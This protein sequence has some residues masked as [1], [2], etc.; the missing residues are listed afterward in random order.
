MIDSK[1]LENKKYNLG[2]KANSLIILTQHKIPVPSFVVIAKED[3][4]MFLKENKLFL[5]LKKWFENEQYDLIKQ[6][7]LNGVFTKDFENKLLVLMSNL[8]I[9][10]CSV[11]SS[12]SNEDG[13]KQ[14]FAGQYETFLKVKPKNVFEAI[15]K[16]WCSLFDSNV[17]AYTGKD[18]LDVFGM[19]VVVQKMINPKFAGVA[20]SRDPISRS[21]N[22]SVVESCVGNGEKLVSG[23]TTP[24]KYQIRR[25]NGEVDLVVGQKMLN[26]NDIKRLE[27]HILKIE[28]IYET[29]MDI[30]WC[31]QGGK[32]FIVQARPITAF[33]ETCEAYIKLLSREKKLFEL[34]LYYK[35][36]FNGIKK[37]TKNLYY[38]KPLIEFCSPEKTN[39]YYNTFTLEELP[40]SIFRELDKNYTQF[41]TSY[42]KVEKYCNELKQVLD[43]K[44]LFS[45]KKV[46]QKLLAIQPFSTLG[47]LAGQNWN[48]SKRVQKLLF[49]YREK[50]DYIIYKT[51]AELEKMILSQLDKEIKPYISVLTID[52]ILNPNLI[53]KKELQN[54][55]KGF[56]YFDDKIH[57][58]SFDKF[59]KVNNF[60]KKEEKS[61]NNISGTSVF[62]G[63]AKGT[64]KIVLN[65]KDFSKFNKG[66]I[67]VTSMTTPKFTEI[68]QKAGGII[69]DEGGFTCH[70]AIVARELRVPCLVGCKNATQILKD[71]ML[72]EL[73]TIEGNVKIIK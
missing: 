14:S 31:F 6:S 35:G 26:K 64:A 12:A 40:Q 61:T 46:F 66:D 70:A 13:A 27:K 23:Q 45:I 56:V 21:L 15:K 36:E 60:C 59:L 43:G 68:M 51:T 54:R 4:E 25:Q 34:E 42:Q 62:S 11:R 24:T 22:Y 33:S 20:F 44:T 10:E 8:G 9:D 63:I 41:K 50:Y 69:T 67:L 18:K 48:I 38:Q 17:I 3:F 71:D 16:C 32:F 19:N 28:K 37:L 52:E 55:L 39:I 29:P 1:H 30:E 57:L 2:G 65:T 53:N 73:N 5:K 72:I 7:I 58:C 47:N 49:S